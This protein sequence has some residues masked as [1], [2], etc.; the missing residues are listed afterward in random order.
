M[1]V[2]EIGTGSGYSTALLADL[3]GRQGHVVSLDVVTDLVDRA[4]SLL[5]AHGHTSTTVIRA[6]GVQGAP[7][8]GPFDRVIAWTTATH[9]PAAWVTQLRPGG[10]MVAPLTL[11]PV[12]KSGIGTR[13]RL[14]DGA[15]PQ[16]DQLFP[17]GFVEM[18]GQELDQWLLPPYG[19]DVLR[20]DDRRHPWWVSAPW[21]RSPTSYPQGQRTLDTLMTEH[22]S[23]P[24]PLEAHENA[25]DFRAWLLATCPHG[26]STAALGEPLWRIGCT[27]PTGVALTDLGTAT[28]TL[29]TADAQ[30]LDT[31]TAWASGWRRAGR[32]GPGEYPGHPTRQCP[33]VVRPRVIP[34]WYHPRTPPGGVVSGSRQ[35][36]AGGLRWRGRSQA[37]RTGAGGAK[38]G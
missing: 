14:A 6:D 19:I 17:A 27:V 32:Q 36:G 11:A 33:R 20:H 31:L 7:E 28:N 3:V 23:A 5:A 2:L 34:Q 4:R 15:T 22:A 10:L 13:I 26:L 12:N 37:T 9:L 35:G 16:V 1:T 30:A 38:A 25:E 21:M 8:Y 24:G 29:T 18:N